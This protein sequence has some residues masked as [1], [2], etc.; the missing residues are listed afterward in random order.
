MAA[1]ASAQQ[2]QLGSGGGVWPQWRKYGAAGGGV[3]V[4]TMSAYSTKLP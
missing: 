4:V 3:M 1:S 2:W